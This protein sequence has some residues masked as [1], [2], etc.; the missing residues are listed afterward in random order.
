M[1]PGSTAPRSLTG[2][3]AEFRPCFTAPT[4]QTFI[5]LV[6]GLVAQTRRRTVCGMLTGGGLDQV[7]H[8]SRAHRLFTHA[9]WSGDALGLALADLIVTHLLPAGSPLTVAVDDTLFKRSGKKVFFWTFSGPCWFLLSAFMPHLRRLLRG[10]PRSVLVFL[11]CRSRVTSFASAARRLM[12][13]PS[14]SPC[15]PLCWASLM[16]SRRL[17]AISAS[18]SRCRGSTRS[19]GQR[20]QACS[21][22][23]G[24]WYNAAKL[25]TASRRCGSSGCRCGVGFGRFLV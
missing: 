20:M 18:R 19:M 24:V 12:R 11:G 25:G 16:R 9:R 1:L 15:Q 21:C 10:M 5:G 3:L 17:C 6:V 2:L 13:S 4:F 14:I 8:H 7:W 23:H 22:R